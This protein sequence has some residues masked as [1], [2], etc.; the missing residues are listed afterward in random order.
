MAI[1]SS[2]YSNLCSDAG[3]MGLTFGDDL[4]SS[5][6]VKLT[7]DDLLNCTTLRL[8][9]VELCRILILLIRYIKVMLN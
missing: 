1:F 4:A 7:Y 6:L 2:G 3:R 9:F 8:V 5:C